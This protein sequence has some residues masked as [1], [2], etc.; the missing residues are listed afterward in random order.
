MKDNC[1]LTNMSDEEIEV[2]FSSGKYKIP[3]S[4]YSRCCLIKSVTQS[5]KPLKWTNITWDAVNY[6]NCE[7]HSIVLNHDRIS[8]KRNGIYELKHKIR[9]QTN[10]KTCINTRL[11][12]NGVET[13]PQSGKTQTGSNNFST[14]ILE[15]TTPMINFKENDYISLQ[16]NHDDKKAKNIFPK[17]SYFSCER[18]Y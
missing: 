12:K 8:I 1:I 9:I 10:D 7:M 4:G 18:R 16:I 3:H 11:V 13:I 15:T 14:I 6:D 5:I 2:I 17:D